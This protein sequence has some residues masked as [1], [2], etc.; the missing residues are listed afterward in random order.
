MDSSIYSVF[1]PPNESRNDRNN[2]HLG[3]QTGRLNTG[4]VICLV[5]LHDNGCLGWGERQSVLAS[6][7]C[8]TILWEN[9]FKLILRNLQIRDTKKYKCLSASYF[10]IMQTTFNEIFKHLNIDVWISC[11]GNGTRIIN[12]WQGSILVLSLKQVIKEQKIT[13]YTWSRILVH[14]AIIVG[15]L[16]PVMTLL[17]TDT[18]TILAIML[19]IILHHSTTRTHFKLITRVQQMNFLMADLSSNKNQLSKH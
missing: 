7:W 2:S 14:F 17:F 15:N 8:Q 13:T 4:R 12:L 3:N 16:H 1:S 19:Y 10:M 18:K 5:D 9:Y 11:L 6:C